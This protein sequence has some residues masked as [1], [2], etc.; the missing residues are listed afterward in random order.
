MVA[1]AVE[2]EVESSSEMTTD[3]ATSNSSD[4]SDSTDSDSS[5]SSRSSSSS[6]GGS[7]GSSGNHRHSS[8]PFC[9]ALYKRQHPKRCEH[10]ICEVEYVESNHDDD[11]LVS[12]P[13]HPIVASLFGMEVPRVVATRFMHFLRNQSLSSSHATTTTPHST[14]IPTLDL[15]TT[16]SP[17]ATIKHS[18]ELS[19]CFREWTYYLIANPAVAVREFIAFV[20][21][22]FCGGGVPPTS[23]PF[24]RIEVCPDAMT[25]S[26]DDLEPERC[27]IGNW[28]MLTGLPDNLPLFFFATTSNQGTTVFLNHNTNLLNRVAQWTTPLPTT[29]ALY[30]LNRLPAVVLN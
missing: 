27:R 5:G 15:L 10:L 2:Q 30:S 19:D 24:S 23:I 18:L 11:E 17:M 25:L 22:N 4:S 29:V 20:K 28:V 7:G 6:G 9:G 1:I 14:F 21:K 26:V 12:I 16:S 13:D 3:S 8:C